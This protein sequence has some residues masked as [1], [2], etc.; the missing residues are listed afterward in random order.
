MM[1]AALPPRD[2]NINLGLVL[3][4][5]L[6]DVAAWQTETPY[7]Y[8]VAT[9]GSAVALFGVLNALYWRKPF[10][11]YDRILSATST[12]GMVWVKEEGV[13]VD[14]GGPLDSRH[15]YYPK[16]T[17]VNRG[18]RMYYRAGGSDSVIGSA[19]SDDG[20][21][22][23]YEQR[24]RVALGGRHGL[25]RLLSPE[26]VSL[27]AN[28]WR[29]YYAGLDERRWR[30]YCARSQDGV[31]WSDEG[32][33]I[34]LSAADDE[35]MSLA[36]EPSVSVS[37]D[38]S[39][40]MHFVGFSQAGATAIY[41]AVSSDGVGWADIAHCEGYGSDACTVRSPCVVSRDSNTMRMYWAEHPLT[42][43]RDLG[44]SIVS[45]VSLD[46]VVWEREEGIRI[47]HGSRYDRHGVLSPDVIRDG[48][49]W[50]MYYAGYLG[51]HWLEPYSLWNY[52]RG[53]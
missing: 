32:V 36:K 46:G 6:A 51:K 1:R 30:I 23:K 14:V 52:R 47:S 53:R 49:R 3:F 7:F 43:V 25:K 35:E 21:E 27:R 39:F 22:W 28:D 13:R 48:D 50:R 9:A 41:T 12:D 8:L 19:F 34:D 24:A 37:G 15:V 45:A 20:V 4:G 17:S 31:V 18:Y 11:A 44:S 10:F 29:L 2:G 38:G 33:C 40:R 16:V 42:A 5:V 26:I